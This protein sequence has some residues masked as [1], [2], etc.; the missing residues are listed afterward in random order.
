MTQ[1]ISQFQAT[2]DV[3]LL[4]Y[5]PRR[6][7]FKSVLEAS[8]SLLPA[9]SLLCDVHL[10]QWPETQ[11]NRRNCEP[12]LRQSGLKFTSLKLPCVL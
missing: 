6:G 2:N 7:R 11:G 5:V 4:Y 12:E 1:V 9:R 3:V 10:N 8:P